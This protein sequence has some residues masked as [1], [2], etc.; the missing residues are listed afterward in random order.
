MNCENCNE[1]LKENWNFCPNCGLMIGSYDM[2]EFLNRQIRELT[3]RI[4]ED[5][6]MEDIIFPKNITITISQ[7]PNENFR[8]KQPKQKTIKLP[9][10]VI[11]P[12]TETA[13][14]NEKYIVIVKLPGVKSKDDVSV[15]AYS[16]SVEVRAIAGDKGYFKLIPI[17]S[18]LNFSG[19]RFEN[20][21]LKLLFE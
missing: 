17:P 12:Q 6:D 14:V 21:E 16:K 15:N 1:K 5:V 18:N 9:E 8:H 2:V 10:N 13:N 19:K 11:E 4:E 7:R 20:E 3:K